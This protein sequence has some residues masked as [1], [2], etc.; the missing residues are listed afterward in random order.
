MHFYSNIFE[1]TD[2]LSFSPRVFSSDST[3]RP[4]GG[5]FTPIPVSTPSV[6]CVLVEVKTQNGVSGPPSEVGEER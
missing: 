5:I 1:A 2:H 6:T 4:V 3:D